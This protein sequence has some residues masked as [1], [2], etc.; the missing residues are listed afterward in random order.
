MRWAEWSGSNVQPTVSNGLFTLNLPPTSTNCHSQ[1]LSVG[2]N[3]GY[4]QRFCGIG[5]VS[6]G[7]HGSVFPTLN[8]IRTFPMFRPGGSGSGDGLPTNMVLFSLRYSL[9][10]FLNCAKSIMTS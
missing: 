8:C 6:A 5:G 3:V 9:S 2:G 4:V 7:N 1:E 10:P